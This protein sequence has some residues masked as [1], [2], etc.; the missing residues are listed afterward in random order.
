MRSGCQARRRTTCRPRSSSSRSP[1][2]TCRFSSRTSATSSGSTS[3]VLGPPVVYPVGDLVQRRH[4]TLEVALDLFR[5]LHGG[6]RPALL[7]LLRPGA[8]P[9]ADE[10]RRHFD[11]A[12]QAEV[13]APGE[14]LVRARC[15]LEHARGAG[16]DAEGLA[17]PVEGFE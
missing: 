5:R 8:Q 6:A 15:V 13:L 9:S 7:D 2:L 16:R 14:P 17:V 1:C 4:T 12:L 10:L 11:V 3:E